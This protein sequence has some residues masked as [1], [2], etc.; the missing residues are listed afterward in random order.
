MSFSPAPFRP[1]RRRGALTALAVALLGIAS[2]PAPLPAQSAAA[3]NA[4]NNA[5]AL[6][7]AGK[8]EEAAASYDAAIKAAPKMFQPYAGRAAVRARLG[9]REKEMADELKEARKGLP[10]E[11]QAEQDAK[12]KAARDKS[13]TLFEGAFAD[14]ETALKMVGKGQKLSLLFD[15]AVAYGQAGE[16]D[17]AVADCDAILKED[18][19]NV[20]AI[21]QRGFTNFLAASVKRKEAGG[22]G[23]EAA[24][25]ASEGDLE[26][27]VTDFTQVITL[28]PKSASAYIQR[29]ACYTYLVEY[30]KGIADYSKA[31]ELEPNNKRAYRNR[32]EIYKAMADI[33]KKTGDNA[34]SADAQKKYEA[35]MAKIKE[36]DAAAPAAPASAAAPAPTAAPK[37]K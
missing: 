14:Y 12:E 24:R 21:Y 18:P 35:D 8:L 20:R 15:R 13:R 37:K 16:F 28:D 31:I 1:A 9:E 5:A 26:K 22:G 3:V 17:K 23:T 4:I 33:A 30:E 10:P 34:G 27:A 25:K 19:K 32:S 11:M 29:G 36:L 6:G 2:L 7:R